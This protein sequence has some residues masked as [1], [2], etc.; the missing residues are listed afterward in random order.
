MSTIATD[1]TKRCAATLGFSAEGAN[2]KYNNWNL[3]SAPLAIETGKHP[4][5]KGFL[6]VGEWKDADV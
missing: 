4:A 5:S 2:S 1:S 3:K 6:G